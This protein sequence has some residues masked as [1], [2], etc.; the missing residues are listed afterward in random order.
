MIATAV[1]GRAGVA[2]PVIAARPSQSA[3]RPGTRQPTRGETPAVRKRSSTVTPLSEKGSI[4]FLPSLD[5]EHSARREHEA[6]SHPE[7]AGRER[8][9]P[10]GTADR[11]LRL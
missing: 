5:G 8:Q 6:A 11:G 9:P 7:L 4:S 3:P 10:P 1:R 2:G